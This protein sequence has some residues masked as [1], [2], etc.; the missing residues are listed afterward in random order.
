MSWRLHEHSRLALEKAMQTNKQSTWY[1][2]VAIM[3]SDSRVMQ[4]FEHYCDDR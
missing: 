3:R 2:V 4:G 1:A